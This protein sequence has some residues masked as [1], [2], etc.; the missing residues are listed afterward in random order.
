MKVLARKKFLA[1]ISASAFGIFLTSCFYRAG[2][3]DFTSSNPASPGRSSLGLE[4]NH[5]PELN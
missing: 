3:I 1:I 5:F 4:Q 2:S